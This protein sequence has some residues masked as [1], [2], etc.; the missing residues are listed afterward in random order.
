MVLSAHGS[1]AAVLVAFSALRLCTFRRHVGGW[2]GGDGP[3]LC[4]RTVGL[5]IV[6]TEA[7]CLAALWLGQSEET[8]W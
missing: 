2:K 8:V 3:R 1:R 4:P 6:Q 5:G 7:L